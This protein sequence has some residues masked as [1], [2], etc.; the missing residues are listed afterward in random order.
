MTLIPTATSTVTFTPEPTLVQAIVQAPEEYGGAV[1][2]AKPSF[3]AAVVVAIGNGTIVYVFPDTY[4]AND[5]T[6]V[7]V[8]LADKREGWL[9]RDLIVT[10]TP[11]PTW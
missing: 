2:R 5:I 9:V 11:K 8:R 4:V 3:D 10:A 1:I 6:W 7:H